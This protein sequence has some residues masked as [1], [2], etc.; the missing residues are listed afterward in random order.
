MQLKFSTQPVAVLPA[1]LHPSKASIAT[2]SD[3]S[4][5]LYQNYI[6]HNERLMF[7]IDLFNINF[8]SFLD[9]FKTTEMLDSAIAKA[10][11]F[12]VIAP[13]TANG[14]IEVL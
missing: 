9:E 3:K 12:G 13:D 6:F 14:I 7:L 4:G 5:F 2:G 11:K 1:S 8:Y 10:A